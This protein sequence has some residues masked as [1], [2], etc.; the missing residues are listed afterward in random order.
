MKNFAIALCGALG[1][2]FAIQAG[3]ANYVVKELNNGPGGTFVFDPS[4]LHVRPGDSV[5]FEPTD[6][7]HNSE[8][9]AIPEGAQAWKSDISQPLTVTFTKQ[10]VY[11][12]QCAPHALFGMVGAIQVSKALNKDA[13]LKAADELEHKQLMNQGRISGLM[14]QIQ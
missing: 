9:V 3:A 11:L 4:Y 2:F 10:G 14:K 1:L 12:Y 7:G 13:V 6:Q 8:S 5:T